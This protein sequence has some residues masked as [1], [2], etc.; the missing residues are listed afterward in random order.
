MALTLLF[1]VRPAGARFI[2]GVSGVFSYIGIP[3]RRRPV[4]A[5]LVI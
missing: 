1:Q 3:C 5:P 4:I 2:F